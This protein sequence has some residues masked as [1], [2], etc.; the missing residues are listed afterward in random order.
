MP[1]LP[2][3]ETVRS[4]LYKLVVGKKVSS[5]DVRVEKMIKNTV[6][7]NILSLTLLLLCTIVYSNE[8]LDKNFL[9]LNFKGSAGQSFGAFSNRFMGIGKGVYMSV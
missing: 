6:K 1:E 7:N 5:V 9:E 3:V 4:T 8:K 2:E